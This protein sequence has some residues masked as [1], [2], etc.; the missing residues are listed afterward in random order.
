MGR[1]VTETILYILRH[2]PVAAGAEVG[3]PAAAAAEAKGIGIYTS[4]KRAEDAIARLRSQ[5]GFRDWPNGF[6]IQ[7]VGLDEDL[8]P[9][10]FLP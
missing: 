4:R 7:M 5:P 6:R 1:S 8:W 2:H 10:G 9:S 3:A